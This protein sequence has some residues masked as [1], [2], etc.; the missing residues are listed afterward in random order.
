MVL[1]EQQ[2]ARAGQQDQRVRGG[3]PGHQQAH[4]DESDVRGLHLWCEEGAGTRC[5][6][7]GAVG[8]EAVSEFR[9]RAVRARRAWRK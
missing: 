7:G 4:R 5:G 3:R 8:T 2:R 9:T 6:V 1:I